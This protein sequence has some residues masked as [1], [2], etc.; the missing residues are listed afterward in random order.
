MGDLCAQTSCVVPSSGSQNANTC[1]AWI[2]DHGGANGSYNNNCNGYLVVYP[3][4]SNGKVSIVEGTYNTESGSDKITIYNGVGTGG[5]QL[6]QWSGNGSVTNRI[7][8]TAA[9]GAL[10]IK[11]YSDYS[12]T[13]QG[14]AL[15]VTCLQSEFMTTTPLTGCLFQWLD[16]GNSG[17][18][19][20]NQDVTQTICSQNGEKFRVT[21]ESF[22]L[23]SGDY[24]YVY[25]GNSTSA[26]PLGTYTGATLPPQI[27]STGS[28]L[29]FRFVSNAGGVSSGWVAFIDCA[30]CVPVSTSS[31]S[32]CAFDN[33]HPFCTD[34]GQYTYNSGTTGTASSY[35]GSSGVGCLGST[36]AP[37][38]YYMRIDQPGNLT[39]YI[40]Q[41]SLATGLG[42]D[43]DFACW[44]PYMASSQ[45]EFVEN[46]CCGFYDHNSTTGYPNN[47]SS[48]ANYP[49]GNLV[50]CSYDQRSYEYCH[51]NN[52]HTGEY[53]LLLITNYSKK[54]GV[55]TFNSTDLS[56]ATT[57]CSI[58][59]QVSN[60][61]PYCVGDTARLFCN[62]PQQGATY[63]WTGPDGWTSS[64]MN[65]TIPVTA[66][67]EG[68]TY[69]LVKT[70]NGS[71]SDTAFT[72]IH[73]MSLNTT[74]NVS[75]SDTVCLGQS[76]MLSASCNIESSQPVGGTCTNVWYPGGQH[77][78]S[79]TVVP[80]VTT[81]YV[82]QQS[83]GNC[84]SKDSVT[85][86]VRNPSAQ[87]HAS[88]T[89]ICRGDTVTMWAECPAESQSCVYQWNPGNQNGQSVAV[90]PT[91]STDYFLQQTID[92]CIARDTLHVQ[93]NLPNLNNDTV[94][95][96]VAR[97]SMPFVYLGQSY[98]TVGMYDIHLTNSHG[99]DSLVT[100]VL[101]YLDTI[102][103]SLDTTVCPTRFPFEWNGVTFHRDSMAS[104][105]FFAHN[106]ADSMVKMTV[107]HY[108]N[109]I[110]SLNMADELCAGDT[111][112][113]SIGISPQSVLQIAENG[114]SQGESQ[115]IFL[116]DGR[117]CPPYGDV[118]RS[119]AN[120]NQFVPGATMTDV[121]DILYVRLK[122]EHSALEDLKMSIVCPNGSR[123]KL[124]A[125]YNQ[126]TGSWGNIPNSYFRTNLGLANRLVEVLSC[127]STLNPIGEPWNYIWSNNTNHNYQYAA[128]T[129]GYC[130]E[131]VNIQSYNNPYWDYDYPWENTHESVKP[132]NPVNMTQIYHPYQSFSNLIGCPL[133]GPWYIE[134]QDLLPNDNGYLTEWELAMSPSLLQIITPS[135]VS[136]QLIGPWVTNITDSTFI[137]TPPAT[138]TSDT[139]V[140]YRFVLQT[141]V[142]CQYDTTVSLTVH[143]NCTVARDTSVCNSDLPV[144]WAGFTFNAAGGQ[145]LRLQTAH[146]CD[147]IVDLT[148]AVKDTSSY[149]ETVES[150]DAY[151]WQ[152]GITYTASTNLPIVRLQNS[153]GCDS[154]VH[155][156]L[157]IL[158]S[159]ESVDEVF[160][161]DSLVWIDGNTYYESTTDPEHVIVM[162]TGC[163]SIVHLHLTLGHSVFTDT[164]AEACG[165]FTWY[166]HENILNS[167]DHLTHVVSKADGCDSTVT[168]HLTI[169]PLPVACFN[170]YTLGENYEIETMLHFEEC[171]PNMVDYHWDMGNSDAFEEP[172]FDYAYRTAGTYR[173]TL[174][175][176]DENGCS[177]ERHRVV[178]I[179]NPELQIFL[180]NS[181]TPDQNGLND[182]FKPVGLHITDDHYLFVI[183]D[184]WGEVMFRTTDPE[185]G[186]DGTYKGQLVPPNSVMTWTLQCASDMGMVRKKGVVVVIY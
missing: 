150:C 173:V 59:A 171:S 6:A 162:P 169:F 110:L 160:A 120:F 35:F 163:D 11:F 42:I 3:E 141:D 121:N 126:T 49:Y 101:R 92:G 103:V 65:P 143:P 36:P 87:I 112:P 117:S 104:V 54:P 131:P 58:M 2:Y 158:N 159:V 123:S 82:L 151:T 155:L 107:Q 78:N 62:N 40:Q 109:P 69:G 99:C 132:S 70:L 31:G 18:Y 168:L 8:S 50:D 165:S 67:M 175:V 53:Y 122:I 66:D 44:G 139:T 45:S 15:H 80:E 145:T 84:V 17:N 56:T 129:Y 180:P 95:R 57:D 86:E 108:P 186:W 140:D 185:Q 52:A 164:V 14:F 125:D 172:A 124:I 47:T 75:A 167:C 76:V 29:T 177:A 137:I 32:P 128:G 77:T 23:A 133:N 19:G 94:Y 43:V 102:F 97:D 183:Y 90:T 4:T 12:I 111:L 39:I 178:V 114:A 174:R 89:E 118:Y 25:D 22:S 27:V 91:T 33:I 30:N 134:V 181:F 184:R 21:F 116:P 148:L 38:W 48:Y 46:L 119:Y 152:D 157:T 106:G 26:F 10:T 146:G 61:G 170:Y 147:S 83:F 16:P 63:S 34:E 156:Q 37:A 115:K 85:I 28:C 51:I 105:H 74:I 179:K 55:I 154:V 149:T 60:D 153:Q 96:R 7:T 135:V 24:L 73:I 98:D 64:Q 81:T 113:V 68:Y 93:V 138:L 130:Y 182:V 13:K 9:N 71:S 41:Y 1:D 142:G 5:T 100:L 88:D 176:T 79:V 72:T 127:D 161:C 20:N 136:K 144:I 166:E